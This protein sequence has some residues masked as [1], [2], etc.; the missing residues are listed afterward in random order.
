MEPVV[1]GLVI[2]GGLV[3]SSLLGCGG[4]VLVTSTQGAA[5]DG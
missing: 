2:L 5:P 4:L 3:A 1:L